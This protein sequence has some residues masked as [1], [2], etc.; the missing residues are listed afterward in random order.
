MKKKSYI[1]VYGIL[2]KDVYLTITS[3]IDVEI[4]EHMSVIDKMNIIFNEILREHRIQYNKENFNV[5]LLDI[6]EIVLK[7]LT[8][9]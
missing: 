2:G 5:Q 9:I 1:V 7:V 3:A 6:S 4:D 8:L